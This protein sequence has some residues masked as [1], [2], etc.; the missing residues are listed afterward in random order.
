MEM[1]VFMKKDDGRDNKNLLKIIKDLTI[2]ANLKYLLC[3]NL[4]VWLL[5]LP[6]LVWL[7][8]GIYLLN[9]FWVQ[10]HFHH[11]SWTFIFVSV[12]L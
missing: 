9:L 12:E 8:I 3:S 7:L 2:L 1:D 5:L 4:L 6:P 11:L 10:T